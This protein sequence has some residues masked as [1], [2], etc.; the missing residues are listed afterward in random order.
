M[1]G[2]TQQLINGNRF[3][4]SNIEL[5]AQ[6][7][8]FKGF[9]EINYQDSLEIGDVRGASQIALGETEGEYSAEGSATVFRREFDQLTARLGDGYGMIRFPITITY[10]N[11]G[12]ATTTDRLPAVRIAGVE[13]GHSQGTDALTM[14]ITLKILAPIERNGR[15]LVRRDA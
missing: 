12:E 7:F 3:Q 1:A 8:R 10:A 2:P 6:G 11:P 5:D 14:Q 13:N 4:F 15:R 9:T